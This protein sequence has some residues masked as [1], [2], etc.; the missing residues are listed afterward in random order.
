MIEHCIFKHCLQHWL[1][2]ADAA[3]RGDTIWRSFCLPRNVFWQFCLSSSL[4]SIAG[5][6]YVLKLKILHSNLNN[7]L[8][9]FEILILTIFLSSNLISIACV[10][11]VGQTC[12]PI[13]WIVSSWVE[14]L[15]LQPEI[16]FQKVRAK[17]RTGPVQ[18]LK[19]KSCTTLVEGK[20][21]A[22]KLLSSGSTAAS[23]TFFSTCVGWEA[24][25][26]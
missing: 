6:P 8:W 18:T 13:V 26:K 3:T 1:F 23:T 17:S 14:V 4:I 21:G 12:C 15:R 19:Q 24:A 9:V 25:L 22:G 11:N 5:V 20:K 16:T 10:P 2:Q 7:F